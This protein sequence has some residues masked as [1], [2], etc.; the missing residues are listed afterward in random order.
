VI[1]VIVQRERKGGVQPFLLLE[2]FTGHP[3]RAGKKHE[4]YGRRC[5]KAERLPADCHHPGP[6]DAKFHD[7]VR[8]KHCPCNAQDCAGA[9][10]ECS[11]VAA[12]ANLCEIGRHEASRGQNSVEVQHDCCKAVAVGMRQE[13]GGTNFRGVQD[14]RPGQ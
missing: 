10:E 4:E 5:G 7:E 9:P 2:A 3:T 12:A 8:P 14:C 6:E 1:G 13:G 11:P